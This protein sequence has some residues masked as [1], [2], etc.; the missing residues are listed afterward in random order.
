MI[1][2]IILATMVLMMAISI[3]LAAGPQG[4]H[5]PGTGLANPETKEAAQGTGQGLKTINETNNSASSPGIHEPG[6][7]IT[8]P[9]VKEAAQGTGQGNQAQAGQPAKEPETPAQKTQPG[10]EFIFA[11][12][13]FIAVA[14]I[15]LGRRN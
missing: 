8:N 6:T 10:F 9:E 2:E 4:I 15:V 3:S 12:M 1:K 11:L 5:E 14:F 13:G 7:G